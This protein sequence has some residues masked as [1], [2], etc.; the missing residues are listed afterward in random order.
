MESLA[1]Y[2]LKRDDVKLQGHVQLESA[3]ANESAVKENK[4]NS[5][6]PCGEPRVTIVQN[7]P[8]FAIV[9]VICPC[10]KTTHIKCQYDSNFPAKEIAQQ[11]PA[12]ENIEEKLEKAEAE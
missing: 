4:D 10:G 3:Q 12:T 9:E 1:G 2:I 6:T 8:E 11:P 7:H 5:G